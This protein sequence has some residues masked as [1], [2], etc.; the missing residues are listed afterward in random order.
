MEALNDPFGA[1]DHEDYLWN[2]GSRP[3]HLPEAV[4]TALFRDIGQ[5]VV[6]AKAEWIAK[7]FSTVISGEQVDTGSCSKKRE[8]IFQ[9]L[10]DTTLSGKLVKNSPC[11]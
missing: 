6:A 10:K 1:Q 7:V 3:T 4:D 9:E 2:V 5:K 11:R 8:N